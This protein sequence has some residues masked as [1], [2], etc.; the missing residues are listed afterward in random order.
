MST[1]SG[2]YIFVRPWRKKPTNA[3]PPKATTPCRSSDQS[4]SMLRTPTPGTGP[5]ARC[6]QLFVWRL[7]SL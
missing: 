6:S 2:I 4:I 1:I 5:P 3:V 7:K